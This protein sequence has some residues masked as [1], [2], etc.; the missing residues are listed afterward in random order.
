VASFAD[1]LA[2]LEAMA[3]FRFL[4]LVTA[5]DLYLPSLLESVFGS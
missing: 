2:M 4:F 1:G 3:A 5:I